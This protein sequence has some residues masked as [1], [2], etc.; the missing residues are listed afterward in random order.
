MDYKKMHRETDFL[1]HEKFFA[2]RIE[3]KRRNL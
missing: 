2:G 3:T 1:L